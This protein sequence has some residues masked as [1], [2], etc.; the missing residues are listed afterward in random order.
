M[1]ADGE[2][3]VT[4]GTS[5]SAPAFAGI[6]T[7][8]N[9]LRARKGL[10]ALGFLHPRLYAAAASSLKRSGASSETSGVPLFFDITV[11]NSSVGGDGYA[12]PSGFE[13]HVGWDAATGWGS[14]R[15]E[16][17]VSALASD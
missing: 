2:L 9:A 12:C 11:G 1:V 7:L 3:L 16:G 6:V 17:L 10:P 4:G 14:P 8:L 15:W 5:A 13:S